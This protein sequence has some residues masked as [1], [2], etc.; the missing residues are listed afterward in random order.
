[1]PAPGTRS[2]RIRAAFAMSARWSRAGDGSS[3]ARR[4]ARLLRRDRLCRRPARPA[5]GRR[6]LGRAAE[7]TI[8]ILTSD[9]G[10]MLGERG[11]WYKMSFF[12]SACRVPLI[13]AGPGRFEPRHVAASVSL[14]DLMP[15]LVEL[16]GG[17]PQSLG[18][19]I[20][21]RSLR[22]PS[23]GRRRTRW[24]DRRVPCRGRDRPGHDDPPGPIESHPLT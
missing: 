9:H 17:D 8:V 7:D 23:A 19:R 18:M 10:E 4:A 20:D 24:G 12:E 21:G 11:L 6:A 15:T 1:M 5:H 3:G 2:M 14:V 16:S 22:T 13:I